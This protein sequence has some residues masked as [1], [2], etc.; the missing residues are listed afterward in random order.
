LLSHQIFLFGL[1]KVYRQAPP[2]PP[3]IETKMNMTKSFTIMGMINNAK[4]DFLTL[5][6]PLI[7]FM[8]D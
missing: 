2:L 7:L 4:F 1:P 5:F 6:L 3:L 8:F